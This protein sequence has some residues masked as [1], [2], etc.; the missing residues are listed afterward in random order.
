MELALD[1]HVHAI[2]IKQENALGSSFL[3]HGLAK[4]GP[5]ES[6]ADFEPDIISF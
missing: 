2:E 1:I 3:L 6:P 5:C 4:I